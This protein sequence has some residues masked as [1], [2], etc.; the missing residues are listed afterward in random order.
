M[1]ARQA[2]EGEGGARR[3]RGRAAAAREVVVGPVEMCAARVARPCKRWGKA[4]G[5][6]C[7]FRFR[8]AL[9][10]IAA[11]PSGHPALA[12]PFLRVFFLVV[13]VGLVG[14]VGFDAP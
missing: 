7:P 11:Y 6:P 10:P 4:R 12:P 14:L 1:E 9:F 13:S 3:R 5:G 8:R 2:C